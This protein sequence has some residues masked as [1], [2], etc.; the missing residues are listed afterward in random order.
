M[1]E[2]EIL[3]GNKLIAD[4]MGWHH[5]EDKKYDAHEMS[6][7]KYHTSWDWLMP[8]VEKIESLRSFVSINSKSCGIWNYFN[9]MEVLRESPSNPNHHKVHCTGA[10]KIEGTYKAV[11]DFIKWCNQNKQS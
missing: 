2:Q 7:L 5:H 3:E 11:L 9:P 1:N 4:F 6:N 8:V 10:T